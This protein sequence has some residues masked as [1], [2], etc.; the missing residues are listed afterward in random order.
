MATIEF[1][2][3]NTELKFADLPGNQLQINFNHLI[4]LKITLV[5]FTYPRGWTGH[6]PLA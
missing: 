3:D 1:S 6:F 4:G 2:L 5:K